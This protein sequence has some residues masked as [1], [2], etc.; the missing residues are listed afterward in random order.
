M[1]F[2]Y[3]FGKISGT[4]KLIQ[5]QKEEDLQ[6]EQSQSNLSNTQNNVKHH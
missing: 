3:L 2:V 6:Q 1:Y 4:E 5:Q